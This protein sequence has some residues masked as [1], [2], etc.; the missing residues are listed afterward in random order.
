MADETLPQTPPTTDP[1]V[2]FDNGIGDLS[3]TVKGTQSSLNV[4][5]LPPDYTLGQS[6][7]D[8]SYK[9]FP[10][11]L[12][13]NSVNC[14][15]I[16]FN[17]NVSQFSQLGSVNGPN[18]AIQPWHTLQ[19]ELSKTDSLRFFID[20]Q[21]SAGGTTLNQGQLTTAPRLTRRIAE[22]VALFMPDTSVYTTNNEYTEVSLADIGQSVIGDYR[23]GMGAGPKGVAAAIAGA[24]G[25]AIGPAFNYYSGLPINPR[26]EVMYKTTAQ[27]RF[28]FE[29]LL[30]PTNEGESL[31]IDQIVRTLRLHSVPEINPISTGIGIFFVKPSEFDITFYYKGREN[32]AIPRINTCVLEQIDIDYAPTGRWATFRNGFPVSAKLMLQFRE[33]EILHKLR[34]LQGF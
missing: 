4:F 28:Q 34:V 30:G 12:G 20:G 26:V 21:F 24:I 14:H 8:F 23:R 29:F 6:Q 31:A 19:N 1:S 11:D 2:S 18:G 3:N 7:Y 13:D 15:Y 27:R 9:V 22:S 17:I 5:N 10:S 32:K 25:G 16:V 33:T